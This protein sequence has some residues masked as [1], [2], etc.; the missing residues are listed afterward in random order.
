MLVYK[1]IFNLSFLQ[2]LSEVTPHPEQYIPL[3]R[4]D[5]SL[6]SESSSMSE[7]IEVYD[8][9]QTLSYQPESPAEAD[10]SQLYE[11]TQPIW[12]ISRE[13]VELLDDELGKGAWGIV[14]KACFRGEIVA[15]KRLHETL[16]EDNPKFLYK[17]IRRELNIASNLRHPNLV[18][19]LG[20][21]I[22]GNLRELIILNELMDS[23][24][25]DVLAEDQ[26]SRSQIKS[27]SID[28]ARALNYLH[29]CKPQPLMHRDVSSA[30]V[31][32]LRLGPDYW[33]AKLS[34][35]GS[36][37]AIN[38]ACTLSPGNPVYAAPE[39]LRGG[40]QSCKMD[41]YS[42]G[43]LLIEMVSCQLPSLQQ[44]A[45]LLEEI[46]WQEMHL[47]IETC[48]QAHPDGRPE[49]QEIIKSLEVYVL[50][51]ISMQPVWLKLSFS[52]ACF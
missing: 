1:R 3:S 23:S 5:E 43:I 47:L 30:N 13:E 50:H 27:F 8:D 52:C 51:E 2:S 19:F 49:M 12:A 31:L 33:K 4:K 15:A 24:L 21:V 38:L 26:L 37:Q 46:K 48:I 6:E 16:S 41:T 11:D 32:L 25:R 45:M 42:F 28:V 22:Q 29:S 34:D 20:A 36:L 18:L 44:R 7:A 17:A 40:K 9:P 14:T 39:A 35:Y 10:K